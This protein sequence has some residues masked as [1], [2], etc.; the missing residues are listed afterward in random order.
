M[1]TDD[2]TREFT[3][4][5]GASFTEDELRAA[6]PGIQSWIELGPTSWVGKLGDGGPD[7]SVTGL[8]L[9]DGRG[10]MIHTTMGRAWLGT[11]HTIAEAGE[12]AQALAARWAAIAIA[13]PTAWLKIEGRGHDG[14]IDR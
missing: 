4:Y 10:D 9:S 1:Q 12:A 14:G 7:L 6:F 2:S 8:H 13:P 11:V 3:P 5:G